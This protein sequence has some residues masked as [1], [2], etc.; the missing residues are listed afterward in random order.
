MMVVPAPGPRVTGAGPSAL[1]PRDCVLE[2]TSAGRPAARRPGALA[3]ADLDQVPQCVAG[4]VTGRFVA[5]VAVSDRQRLDTDQKFPAS[6]RPQSPASVPARGPVAVLPGKRGTAPVAWSAPG[7]RTPPIWRAGPGWRAAAG[8]PRAAV[9]G[10]MAV[11]VG[12]RHAPGGPGIPGGGTGQ[13]TGQSRVD[14]TKSA[15]SPGR[16]ARPSSVVSGMVRLMRAAIPAKESVVLLSWP[17]NPGR[18][19]PKPPVRA[20]PG[21]PPP[22]LR[23]PSPVPPSPVPPSPVP[24]SPVPPSPVPPSPVPPSPVPPSPVPP[25]PVPPSPVPPSPVPPSPVPPSPVP[26]S[27]VPPSPRAAFAC[28]AF[29]CAAFACA[30]FARAAFARAAFARAAFARAAFA[31]A[32]FARV[33]SAGGTTGFLSGRRIAD[34]ARARRMGADAQGQ[35]EE[36]AGT[37]PVQG[38]LQPGRFQFPRIGGDA[39]V[40]GQRLGR[41]KVPAAQRRG[42][43]VFAPEFHPRVPLRLFPPGLCGA[44]IDRR[45]GTG[46]RHPQLSR[47][48]AGHVVQDQGLGGRRVRRIQDP[49]DI[50]DDPRF[51]DVDGPIAQGAGRAAQSAREI[52]SQGESLLGGLPG[53]CGRRSELVPAELSPRGRYRARPGRL[54]SG[55]GAASDQLRD[56][57]ELPFAGPRFDP[58]PGTQ[59][60]DQL[61]IGRTVAAAV[62]PGCIVGE[63]HQS[64][65]RPHGIQHIAGGETRRRARRQG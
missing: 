23:S 44:R 46:D 45:H 49:R 58:I 18:S 4:L 8:G 33:A 50:G 28:A 29:A 11:F 38:A 47:S 7:W 40:G 41:W 20:S 53:R 24:P 62:R 19:G 61:I 42:A 63:S 6:P 30:A 31:R 12:Y 2:V 13:G 5:V 52:I 39:L 36:R 3:V 51:V 34:V 32:A 64:H 48:L 43:G 57:R 65:T 15:A 59:N 54:T 56:H 21:S 1:I 9:G 14:R 26:P 25:S 35:V 37:E 17:P 16:S 55:S 60:T 27:P 10:G 22:A